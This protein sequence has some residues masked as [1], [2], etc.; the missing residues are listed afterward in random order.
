MQIH[1]KASRWLNGTRQHSSPAYPSAGYLYSG[2]NIPSLASHPLNSVS[3]PL[4]LKS[5]CGTH[6]GQYTMVVG[7]LCDFGG[8]AWDISHLLL[9]FSWNV[10]KP[11]RRLG[12][13]GPAVPD[14]PA[15]L[16]LQP[17]T[18]AKCNIVLE[19]RQILAEEPPGQPATFWY[20]INLLLF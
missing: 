19:P 13:R 17:A 5:A 3:F 7:T 18:L 15:E 2:H 14:A 12:E 8:K 6:T 9:S 20:I 1:S 4:E 16:R 10:A 11:Q